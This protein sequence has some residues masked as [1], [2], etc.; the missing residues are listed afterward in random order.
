MSS[1]A[2]NG[3]VARLSPGVDTLGPKLKLVHDAAIKKCDGIDGAKDGLIGN[4][5]KCRFDPAILKCKAG[6]GSSCLSKPEVNAFRAIYAGTR[7][8][9]GTLIMPGFPPGSELEWSGWFTA[10][11]G[12]APEWPK[13]FFA[14]WSMTTRVGIGRTSCST[15]TMLPRSNAWLPSPTRPMRTC[16]LSRS[17][18]ASS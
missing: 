18:A 9:D 3:A 8:R 2:R 13:S 1:F 11:K 15:A 4:P 10:P 12:Q 6:A 16:G 17:A 7:T 14:T 5:A